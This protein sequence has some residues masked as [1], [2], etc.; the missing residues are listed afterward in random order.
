[1][2]RAQQEKLAALVSQ[3]V[4]WQCR[5]DRYTSIAIGGPA[6]AVVKVDRRRGIAT[7]AGLFG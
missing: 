6:E 1:M 2:N 4:N 7:V 3:P 5:L